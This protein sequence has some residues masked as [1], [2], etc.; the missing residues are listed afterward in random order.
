MN[1]SDKESRLQDEID[2]NLKKVYDDV[3]NEE[4]PDR[5]TQLLQRLRESDRSGPASD[6]DQS[7]AKAGQTGSEE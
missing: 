3:L 6:A 4:I 5:F 1:P 7:G 2:A